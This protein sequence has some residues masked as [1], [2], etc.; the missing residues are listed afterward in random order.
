MKSVNNKY[1]KAEGAEKER[2]LDRLKELNQI[3]RELEGL[4]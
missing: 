2:L 3:K 1:K 4:L